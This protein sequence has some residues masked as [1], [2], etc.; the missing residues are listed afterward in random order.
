MGFIVHDRPYHLHLCSQ[1]GAEPF[2]IASYGT[3]QYDY[4][5]SGPNSDDHPAMKEL[6]RRV[7]RLGLLN[8]DLF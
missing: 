5:I 8:D 4:I 2:F 3:G 7:L 6:Q 1:S